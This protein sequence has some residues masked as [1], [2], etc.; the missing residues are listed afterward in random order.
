M[1]NTDRVQTFVEQ[2]WGDEIEAALVDYIRI[3]N[4]SPA[5]DPEWKRNG[6]MDRAVELVG[7]WCRKQSSR[8][9]DLQ[10]EI[11]EHEGRTPLLFMEIPRAW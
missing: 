1:M 3:P 2:I 7:D 9:K 11:I 5:F 4:K 10:I 6:H 8:L